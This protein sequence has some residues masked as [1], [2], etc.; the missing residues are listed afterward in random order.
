MA[1]DFTDI[2]KNLPSGNNMGGIGQIVYYALHRDVAKW[3]IRPKAGADITIE[4]MGEL[5]G[6]IEMKAGKAFHKLYITDDEGKLDFEGVGEKDGEK[7]YCKTE[8]LQP[9]ITI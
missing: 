7:F 4:Q 8:S 1:I 2:T 6:N 3:P 9:G 5:S